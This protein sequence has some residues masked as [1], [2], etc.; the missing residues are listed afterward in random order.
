MKLIPERI[1]IRASIKGY[2]NLDGLSSGTEMEATFLVPPGTTT[3]ELGKELDL[4][5]VYLQTKVLAAEAARGAL[6]EGIASYCKARLS[7]RVT[8][9]KN[10]GTS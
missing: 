8:Y 3:Q 10:N 9:V 2:G 5:A 1:S 7:E 6:P 4:A